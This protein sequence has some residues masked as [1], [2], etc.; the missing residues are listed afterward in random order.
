M[1]P[2]DG[3]TVIEIDN[4][5]AAPSACAILCD[6]GAD[7]IKVEPLG[8]DPMRN[9]SRTPKIDDGP[10]KDH[11][12]QFDVA[13]RGKQ[14]IAVDLTSDDGI[15]LIL[16]LC[17][18]ADVFVCNLLP[19]RQERFG[20]DPDSMLAVKPSLVHATLTGYGTE[21]PESWRPG[22]DVTSFFGRS[23][24]YY[25]MREGPEGVP[26]MARTAQGDYTTGLALVGAILAALR[27]VDRTGE[28]QVVET[29]LYE[30]A[31][32][33]QATDYS[34][35]LQDKAVFR[36][37]DRDHQ[38]IATANRF[39]C[40]DGN[41]IVLNMPRESGWPKVCGA[42]GLDSLTED[43][44][45]ID[46]RARFRNMPELIAEFDRVFLTRTRDEWGA[47]FDETGVVW[48]PVLG[49]H[50][51][52]A[53]P[54]AAALNMFPTVSSEKLGDYETV[55]HPLKFKRLDV[56]PAATSPTVGQHTRT[57]LSHAGFDDAE[58]QALLASE[59][60]AES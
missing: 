49:L 47:I 42:L 22:Y 28:G 10:R 6:L 59:T 23:G 27:L 21:G 43:E 18:Q 33:T 12:W 31:V 7:V 17:T 14:S 55:A 36:P 2:L 54:Q 58:I 20:L 9:Q 35:T 29:S 45:F 46:M 48:G 60:V 19:K 50:E 37:R 13:N 5:M 38:V 8:G 32:W 24:L 16:R 39:P 40:G 4:W 1:R 57:V 11:D 41:W 52:V 26:P 53:D 15:A 51:V 56:N 30:T 3:V 25:M 34:V 44:R